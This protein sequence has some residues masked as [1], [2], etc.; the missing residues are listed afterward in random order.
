[1][2][3]DCD[4]CDWRCKQC[5]CDCCDDGD[6]NQNQQRARPEQQV[7]DKNSGSGAAA[8]SVDLPEGDSENS[9]AS[10]PLVFFDVVVGDQAAQRIEMRLFRS[11]VPLT[12]ENFRVLCCCG[13]EG[14][15][16]TTFHKVFP[17]FALVGGK[18]SPERGSFADENF[19]KKHKCAGLLSMCN[20]GGPNTNTSLFFITLAA[21]PWLDNKHVVFGKVTKGLE[22]VRA[23]GELGSTKGDPS[24]PATIVACGQVLE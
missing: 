4:C 1:M 13:T 7:A 16:G 2:C 6:S 11:V 14:F 17:G 9:S 12:A 19:A 5:Q 15:L 8:D 22:V 21:A 23:I 10:D 24:Q 3:D 20:E 18:V